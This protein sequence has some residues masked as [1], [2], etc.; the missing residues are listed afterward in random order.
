MLKFCSSP[1]LDLYQTM[2]ALLIN[3]Q[4]DIVKDIEVSFHIM[5][6]TD[7]NWTLYGH[8]QPRSMRD[9]LPYSQ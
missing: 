7:H 3:L 5:N 8:I 9:I 1:Q 2:E 6:F 4:P